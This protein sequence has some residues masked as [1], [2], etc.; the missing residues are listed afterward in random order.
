[1]TK[2]V[3]SSGATSARKSTWEGL[4]WSTLEKQVKRLQMRIAKATREGK[5]NKVKALQWLLTHSFSG[6]CCAVKRVVQ[7]KGA[8]T[9]GVDNILWRNSKQRMNAVL[10]LKRRGYTP[11]PLKRIYIPKK[12]SELRPLSI[13]SMIDRGMQALYLLA[14][15]P[16]AE[17]LADPNSY[18]FRPKRSAADAIEQCHTVL[19]RSHSAQWIFEGDIKACFDR[20]SS[21]WL[22]ENITMDKTILMKFLKA[23]YIEKGAWHPTADGTPQGGLISPTLLV[24]TLAGFERSIKRLFKRNSKVNIIVYA[25]DFVITGP[26]R[27]ILDIVVIPTVEKFLGER[28]L[29]LS[30]EKS[31]ITHIDDGFDFLGFNIRKYSNRKTLTKPSKAGI[32]RFLANIKQVIVSNKAAK[33]EHLIR[34]LNPKI[35]G[36]ANYYRGAVASRVFTYIDNV[37]YQTLAK[38]I[39][40]RHRNKGKIWITKKYFRSKGLD[41]WQ[42]F[43]KVKGENNK[44]EF[45]DLVSASSTKIKRHIKIRGEANPYN[46][47]YKEYFLWLSKIRSSNS[48]W[49]DNVGS[50]KA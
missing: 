29:T 37:I 11:L 16:I 4:K 9:P 33:T 49:A 5:Q 8:T 31:R 15:E 30:K 26:S 48:S 17:E 14:L 25:D 40:G 13:P 35:R 45:L 22:E 43:A 32:K 47:K 38:W 2:I 39:L 24:L 21:K 41:N 20:I 46:P 36:W 18:G 50:L 12:N 10:S 27:E 1:M 44:P 3:K 7:N 23:G 28:G 6:K 34:L 42:F 19:C